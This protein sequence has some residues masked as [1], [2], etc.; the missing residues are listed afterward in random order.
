M[1]HKILSKEEARMRMKA[2]II[3]ARR[4]NQGETSTPELHDELVEEA[5]AIIDG[6]E[7]DSLWRD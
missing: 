5:R 7:Q 3:N 4:R 2:R 6:D 1:K